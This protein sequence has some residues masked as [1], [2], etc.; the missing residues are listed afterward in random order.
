MMPAGFCFAGGV[1]DASR[2]TFL[3][4]K[5]W[6]DPR[7]IR[8][9]EQQIFDAVFDAIRGARKFVLLDMFYYND[10]QRGKPDTTR[11]LSSELTDVL[12]QQKKTCPDMT[13][14]VITDPINTVY[15]SLRSAQFALLHDAGIPVVF[16]DL[17]RLRDSNPTYSVF[18]RLFVEPLGNSEGGFLPNPFDPRSRATF[19]SYLALLNYKANHRKVLV[20]D[21]GDDLVGIVSSANPQDASG[22]NSNVAIRFTGPAAE[23][24]LASENAV[25]HLSGEKPVEPPVTAREQ[26]SGVT[27]QILTERAVKT[28]VLRITDETQPG[29]RIDLAMFFLSDRDVIA[30]LIGARRRG[31][32]IRVLLDPNKD[33]FGHRKYGIPNRPV[34]AELVKAGIDVCWGDTHGEQCHAKMMLVETTSGQGLLLLGSANMTRRNLDNFNL[35]TSA[36]VR[37][38]SDSEVLAGARR[39]FD[40]LWNNTDERIFSAPYEDY[41]NESVVRKWLYRFME[42]SGWSTF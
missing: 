29:D 10:F 3:S 25:L 1:H 26:L 33:S 42:A 39:H 18:W 4:D 40:L 34:A 30:A 14:V 24:L 5:T 36:L 31:V 11:L 35:E 13:I 7:G 28:E 20:A 16:T 9:T 8:H 22:A 17:S 32:S 19:R 27:V 37:A 21:D 15:G 41:R 2:V 23:D 38:S 6:V 12:L